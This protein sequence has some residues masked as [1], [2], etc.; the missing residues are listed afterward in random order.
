MTP[1]EQQSRE[2]VE[3]SLL[4]EIDQL[5]EELY[6]HRAA[7]RLTAAAVN[8]HGITTV[9]NKMLQATEGQYLLRSLL[10]YAVTKIEELAIERREA[11][12]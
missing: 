12:E 4:A 10:L 11:A 7:F 6:E 5:Q 2:K 3:A 9:V 8:Q 1:E